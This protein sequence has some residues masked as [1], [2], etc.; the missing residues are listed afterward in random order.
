MR[1]VKQQPIWKRRF[2]IAP[3]TATLLGI[4]LGCAVA[5]ISAFLPPRVCSYGEY[6]ILL[7][8]LVPIAGISGYGMWLSGDPS[9][10]RRLEKISQSVMLP[11]ILWLFAAFPNFWLSMAS[12]L[13]PGMFLMFI[14]FVCGLVVCVV[15]AG[16]GL[17]HF[18]GYLTSFVQRGGK[19]GGNPPAEGL[20]D[21]ELDGG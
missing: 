16:V 3:G 2:S 10:H 5:T 14:G 12:V 9:R 8:S 21:R 20:W 6:S 19:V 11:A 1:F 7:L 15:I 4:A 18:V 13:G 17:A